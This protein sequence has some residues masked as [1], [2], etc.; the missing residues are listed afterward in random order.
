MLGQISSYGVF[1]HMKWVRSNIKH[2]SRLALFALAIQFVLAFGHFHA[3]AAQAAPA[4]DGSGISLLQAA[5]IASSSTLPASDRDTDQ[6]GNDPCAIC[7]VVAMAS[8]VLFAAP[9]VLPQ[10][11]AVEFRYLTIAAATVVAASSRVAFQPRAPP[12]S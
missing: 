5:T 4:V 12:A 6:H 3:L 9:P 8:A 2:G 11:Q 10:P 7:A 1:P